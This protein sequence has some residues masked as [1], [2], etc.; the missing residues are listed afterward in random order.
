M[1]LEDLAQ[2]CH[3]NIIE[4][5]ERQ[6]TDNENMKGGGGIVIERASTTSEVGRW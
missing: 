4:A 3:F 2:S 5:Q 1:L 6:K